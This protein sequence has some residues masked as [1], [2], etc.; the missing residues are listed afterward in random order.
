M[1]ES[2][3]FNVKQSYLTKP[4]ST[5]NIASDSASA[6]AFGVAGTSYDKLIYPAPY[7]IGFVH[8]LPSRIWKKFTT[9]GILE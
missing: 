7:C 5:R 8:G 9:A 4:H 2:W 6:V 3:G 1:V